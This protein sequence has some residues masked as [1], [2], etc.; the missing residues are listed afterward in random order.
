MFDDTH[1][2]RRMRPLLERAKVVERD[3]GLPLEEDWGDE[4][5]P[6]RLEHHLAEVRD[7]I[8]G[9]D[10]MTLFAI[11]VPSHELVLYYGIDKRGELYFSNI[12][13]L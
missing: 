11:P 4:L 9:G 13:L 8:G 5:H 1:L 3:C 10:E 7:W 6:N 2:S 12:S